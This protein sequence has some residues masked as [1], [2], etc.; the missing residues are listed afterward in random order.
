MVAASRHDLEVPGC[1]LHS[2]EVTAAAPLLR[3]PFAA[4]CPTRQVLDRIG[5]RWTVL[6]L[7]LLDRGTHRFGELTREIEGISPKVLTQT[8]RALERDG[9]VSRE[10][11]AEVPPRTQYSLTD[12]GST[13][14][15]AVRALE[16][17]ATAHLD[18]VEAARAAYD[19]R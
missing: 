19:A 16:R 11:F 10:V 15:G 13:L 12:L 1:P 14:L 17:W 3:S 9:L 5:D 2:R 6:V 7:L 4:A 8:L 18:E